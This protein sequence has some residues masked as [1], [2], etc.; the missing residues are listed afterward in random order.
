M[1]KKKTILLLAIAA[2]LVG[3]IHSLQSQAAESTAQT[4]P[5]LAVGDTFTVSKITYRVSSVTGA[6]EVQAIDSPAIL[7][8]ITIPGN[9]TYEGISYAV[10]SIPNGAFYGNYKTTKIVISEGVKSVG[11]SAFKGCDAVTEIVLPSTLESF[12]TM[13]FK[14]LQTITL[15]SGNPYFQLK[16]GVLFTKNGLKL[17]LYPSGKSGSSYMVP[18]GTTTIVESAFYQNQ[19]LQTIT[20]PNS[21]TTIE[22]YAFDTLHSLTN[23]T[24]GSSI[25]S[26]GEF[27]LRN[28]S[29]L[30]SV[31]LS[32]SGRLG[33]YSIYDCPVLETITID[34]NLSGYR[35]YVFYNLPSL[36]KYEVKK[37]PYYSD[38]D[39]V[40]YNKGELLRYPAAKTNTQYVVPDGTTKI[41]GL[42]FNYM[43][44]TK[45]I[46]LTPGVYVELLAFYY[47]NTSS[48]I[49]IYFRDHKTVSLSKSSSGVFVGLNSG[50]HI[51]LPGDKAVTSFNSYGSAVKPKSAATVSKKTIPA[52][53]IK[54]NETSIEMNKGESFTLTGTLAPYYSTDEIQWDSS[55]TD[56]ATVSADGVIKAIK[57][58]TCKITATTDSGITKSCSVTVL[59]EEVIEST[60]EKEPDKNNSNTTGSTGSS[61]S[62][63]KNN[64][65]DNPETNKDTEKDSSSKNETN[66]TE[67]KND[68]KEV[69][70]DDGTEENIFE[71]FVNSFTDKK[72]EDKESA[73]EETEKKP[74]QDSKL[75]IPVAGGLVVLV[76]VVFF[77]TMKN[78]MSQNAKGKI[79][80]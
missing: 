65:S 23:M 39:G 57:K 29:K 16:D 59:K 8:T 79:Q 47:P 12:T 10:T 34:G 32:N 72:E 41:A 56:I 80:Q 71:Q 31:T 24:F 3:G 5:L 73:S 26:V 18:S 40:L 42:A 53:E 69:S 63:D 25:S 60:D 54:L 17:W 1:R 61:S 7:S 4:S 35:E 11:A 45:E 55:N 50:S 13:G 48:P 14:K 38:K 27:N 78:R 76:G 37:S 22:A 21:V 20:L 36:K 28:C 52:T 15:D 43:Q 75:W 30:K 70:K 66:E 51:Y 67:S 62:E 6:L 64:S 33:Q 9:V 2:L 46:I 68:S 49:T 44:H 19:Y 77:V 58:G 74:E